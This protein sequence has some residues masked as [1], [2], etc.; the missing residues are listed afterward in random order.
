MASLITICVVCV[1]KTLVARNGGSSVSVEAGEIPTYRPTAEQF[2]DVIAYIE[3]ISAEAQRYG[4]CR[5]IPP[6][7]SRKVCSVVHVQTPAGFQVYQPTVDDSCCFL[8]I[9]ANH[10]CGC[11]S[12]PAS[13]NVSFDTSICC[14][15][16]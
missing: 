16:L 9:S 2:D 14:I 12:T 7:D 4:M 5:I 15:P 10:I 3:S 13:F 11:M 1:G 6:P 8:G